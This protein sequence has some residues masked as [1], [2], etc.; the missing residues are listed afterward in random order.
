M[1]APHLLLKLCQ[2]SELAFLHAAWKSPQS[3]NHKHINSFYRV[4][5]KKKNTS[6]S[7]SLSKFRDGVHIMIEIQRGKTS[8]SSLTGLTG[9]FIGTWESKSPIDTV[10]AAV[11]KPLVWHVMNKHAESFKT[12][13]GTRF[14]KTTSD[15]VIFHKWGVFMYLPQCLN[16][17]SI[18]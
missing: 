13:R 10:A 14:Y 17:T 12:V 7:K 6:D 3:M 16:L 4:K 18:L 11:S 5:N 8:Q 2:L 9:L 1:K 15:V